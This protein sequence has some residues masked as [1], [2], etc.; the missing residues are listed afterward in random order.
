VEIS[1]GGE[2][3]VQEITA[4]LL[5]VWL[6]NQSVKSGFNLTEKSGATFGIIHWL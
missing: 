1:T 3:S 2:R 6:K 5:A 4:F